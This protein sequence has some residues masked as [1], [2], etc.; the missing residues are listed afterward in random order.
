[1]HHSIKKN[2]ANSITGLGIIAGVV[3]CILARVHP[4]WIIAECLFFVAL[5]TDALDGKVARIFGSTK[6][7]PY[8]DD[9]ADLINF[10]IHP[11]LWI[12]I[13]SGRFW[14]ACVYL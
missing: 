1:M 5:I 4:S 2:L 12:W 14:L 3:A 11:A 13:E 10:G 9:I 8:L 7:G 6:A